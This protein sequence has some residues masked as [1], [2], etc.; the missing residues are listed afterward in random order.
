[1]RYK[2]AMFA[3]FG[4]QLAAA[5]AVNLFPSRVYGELE[6]AFSLLPTIIYYQVSDCWHDRHSQSLHDRHH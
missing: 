4:F 3:S 1:M 2:G 5:V 6:F